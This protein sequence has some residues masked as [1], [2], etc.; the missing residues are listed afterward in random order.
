MN[1]PRRIP[2]A[3]DVAVID[4]AMSL[5]PAK[6]LVTVA[7]LG[8]LVAC[9]EPPAPVYPIPEGA[10]SI[11]WEEQ[12][13]ET[14]G[15]RCRITLWSDGRSEMRVFPSQYSL[16]QGGLR[17][18]PGW[19]AEEGTRG[20]PTFVRRGVFPSDEARERFRSAWRA[21]IGRIEPSRA[22]Y[23]DGEGI[24][25]ALRVG[26]KVEETVIP[27]FPAEE[28]ESPCHRRFEAVAEIL[29]PCDWTAYTRIG[30]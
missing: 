10:E 21:G 2:P 23:L 25:V 12:N 13:W 15:G 16:R 22:E 5:F 26:G 9:G 29:G 8:A 28:E 30:D 27:M 17:P 20:G 11:V 3:G 1:T 7:L 19:R 6:V 18:L 4:D 24:R 14:G